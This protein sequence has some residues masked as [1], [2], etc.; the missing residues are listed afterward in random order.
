LLQLNS[1]LY[2]IF[3]YNHLKVLKNQPL[4]YL[5]KNELL[6]EEVS[7][8]IYFF[9]QKCHLLDLIH[10]FSQSYSTLIH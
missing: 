8:H 10:H 9:L 4:C 5:V 3:F 6:F 7:T 1:F 2:S